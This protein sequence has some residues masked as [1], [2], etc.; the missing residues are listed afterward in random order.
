MEATQQCTTFLIL[1]P[2]PWLLSGTLLVG[3]RFVAVP[4]RDTHGQTERL[5]IEA[6]YFQR[7]L[8]RPTSYF[9]QTSKQYSLYDYYFGSPAEIQRPAVTPTHESR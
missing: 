1:L 5:L 7:T 4:L 2:R 3:S 9:I 6:K 8:Q